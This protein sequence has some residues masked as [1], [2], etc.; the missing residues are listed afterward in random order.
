MGTGEKADGIASGLNPGD[1]PPD[2]TRATLGD[3]DPLAHPISS[4]RL[5]G[6]TKRALRTALLTASRPTAAARMLPTLLIADAVRCGT[7]SMVGALSHHPAVGRPLLPWT[8]EVHFLTTGT[9]AGLPG[10][11]ATSRSGRAWNAPP[12]RSA[13]RSRRPSSP[14]STKCYIRWCTSGSSATCPT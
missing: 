14:A 7:T 9:I 1:G 4:R 3:R 8:R 11:R 5:G 13:R 10:T 6:T 12:V 2:S